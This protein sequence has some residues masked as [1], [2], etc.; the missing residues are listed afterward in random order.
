MIA[1]TDLHQKDQDV[2]HLLRGEVGVRR[3]WGDGGGGDPV[4]RHPFDVGVIVS[5]FFR[6]SRKKI[7]WQGL[8]NWSVEKLETGT[9]KLQK[10]VSIN[11]QIRKKDGEDF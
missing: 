11:F 5:D 3:H 7:R 6:E 1:V 10:V 8:M 9:T 4:L 2:T